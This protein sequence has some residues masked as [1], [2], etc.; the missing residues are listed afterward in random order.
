[1]DFL[2]HVENPDQVIIEA[3]RVL[4]P[5]GIFVFHTF[6]RNPLSHLVIIKGMEWFVKNTPPHLHVIRLFVKPAELKE[7]C[8][9]AG[10]KVNQLNGIAP[11]LGLNF[12]KMIFTGVVPDGFQFKITQSTLLSYVGLAKKI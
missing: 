3:S 2:E 8:R 9:R 12:L 1:M 6:N 11:K 5:N 7:Y 10:M 4:K